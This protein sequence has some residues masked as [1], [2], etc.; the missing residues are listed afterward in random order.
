MKHYLLLKGNAWER[1]VIK[2]VSCQ[3]EDL[4][5]HGGGAVVLQTRLL[6]RN[7]EQHLDKINK[8]KNIRSDDQLL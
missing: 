5:E 7:Q 4:D 2:A 3:G 1:H 6:L 8:K